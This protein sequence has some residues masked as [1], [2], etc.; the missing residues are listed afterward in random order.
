M[1][2]EILLVCVGIFL[3][4]V[5]IELRRSCLFDR[6]KGMVMRYVQSVSV[7]DWLDADWREWDGKNIWVMNSIQTTYDGEDSRLNLSG[8]IFVGLGHFHL[9]LIIDV[10][11]ISNLKDAQR[12]M[13]L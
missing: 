5:L 6:R 10:D 12:V 1:F 11:D 4:Y 3:V 7:E 2:W 13:G 8:V 9:S